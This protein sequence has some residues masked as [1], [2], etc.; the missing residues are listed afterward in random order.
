MS[1][2]NRARRR[3]RYALFKMQKG[4]CFWCKQPMRLLDLGTLRRAKKLPHDMC[5]IDHLEPRWHPERGR[6]EGAGDFRLVAA[7]LK[8]NNER[9]RELHKLIPRELLHKASMGHKPIILAKEHA[10]VLAPL[11]P[12]VMVPKPR[13]LRFTFEPES[14][15]GA[16]AGPLRVALGELA[17]AKR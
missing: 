9:D 5:T 16:A 12:E 10:D 11:F 14:K 3:K 15:L 2:S 8:C 7:C 13:A 17:H 4:L 1:G 6:Y